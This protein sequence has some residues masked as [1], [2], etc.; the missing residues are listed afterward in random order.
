[1]LTRLAKLDRGEYGALIL[2]A[3]GLKRLGLSARISRFFE[4]AEMLPAAGQGIM[5]IVTRNENTDDFLRA[6]G[7][8]NSALCACAERA[9][10]S[11]LG[12]DCSSPIGAFAEVHD[13][14]LTLR[15]WYIDAEKG[16]KPPGRG[17]ISGDKNL[18]E[19]L[20]RELAKELLG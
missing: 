6:A 5:C 7:C 3:A 2:A 15:G 1:V 20:G 10:V 8:E 18:A 11:T 14:T 12:G 17:S 19:N 4:T 9:F 13:N 16:L